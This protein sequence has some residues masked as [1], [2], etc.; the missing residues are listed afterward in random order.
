MKIFRFIRLL[1]QL[2]DRDLVIHIPLVRITI[3]KRSVLVLYRKVKLTTSFYML[4]FKLPNDHASSENV[5]KYKN[6]KGYFWAASADGTRLLLLLK[7][8]FLSFCFLLS[9]HCLFK[10]FISWLLCK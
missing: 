8:L 2:T 1:V 10:C 4:K 7:T 9:K 6:C 3:I 5:F